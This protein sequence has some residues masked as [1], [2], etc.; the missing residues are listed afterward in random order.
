MDTKT[1]TQ[2]IKNIELKMLKKE[3]NAIIEEKIR[4]SPKISPDASPKN[5]KS[6]DTSQNSKNK[7]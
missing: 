3:I 1:H 2:L 6:V 5:N 7:P 4:T